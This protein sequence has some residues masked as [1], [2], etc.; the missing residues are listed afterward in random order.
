M[1]TGLR[2]FSVG[3]VSAWLHPHCT[4]GLSPCIYK[5]DVQGLPA[6]GRAEGRAKRTGS[7]PLSRDACNPYYE[8]PPARDNTFPPCVLSCANPSGQGHA[9]INSL[10]GSVEGPRVRD[11]D[12]TDVLSFVDILSK[13]SWYFVSICHGILS[14]SIFRI[15]SDTIS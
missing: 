1:Y 4:S 14:K 12:N 10:V 7:L 13:W 11:A 8:H 6:R 5:R 15:V 3:H 2:H 9:A